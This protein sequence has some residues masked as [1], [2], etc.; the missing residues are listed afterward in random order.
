MPNLA[1]VKD[2]ETWKNVMFPNKIHR[3]LPYI[4]RISIVRHTQGKQPN[5][6]NSTV[7]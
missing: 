2:V 3:S 6:Y 5:M 1:E 7:L 4:K